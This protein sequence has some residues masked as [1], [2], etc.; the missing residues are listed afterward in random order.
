MLPELSLNHGSAGSAASEVMRRLYGE[1]AHSI[2]FDESAVP[3]IVLLYTSFRADYW[4]HFR[5][6]GLRGDTFSK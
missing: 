5:R 4:R 2:T 1:A 6:A 3:S